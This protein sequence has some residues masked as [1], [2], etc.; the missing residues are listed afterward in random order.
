MYMCVVGCH[1][2]FSCFIWFVVFSMVVVQFGFFF[3]LYYIQAF[4]SLFHLD[5]LSHR[6]RHHQQQPFANLIQFAYC[7]CIVVHLL[8]YCCW[9][10]YPQIFHIFIAFVVFSLYAHPSSVRFY[11]FSFISYHFLNVEKILKN[12][13][14][15]KLKILVTWKRGIFL[16]CFIHDSFSI[17]SI[18]ESDFPSNAVEISNR[19]GKHQKI[20]RMNI[21]IWFQAIDGMCSYIRC[22]CRC[23]FLF[24]YKI[25]IQHLLYG[26]SIGL[27]YKSEGNK[28]KDVRIYNEQMKKKVNRKN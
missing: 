15:E 21:S 23:L 18:Y 17:F 7:C 11:E 3:H 26:A 19:I 10:I 1:Y 16:L 8:G 2:I 20:R 28:T 27:S 24:W 13:Y 25:K 9:C 12:K 14:E 22:C 6:R 4:C 5:A